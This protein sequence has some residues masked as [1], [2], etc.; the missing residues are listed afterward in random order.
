MSVS[1]Y[2]TYWTPGSLPPTTHVT[3]W[4]AGPATDFNPLDATPRPTA[5]KPLF[6]YDCPEG[7]PISNRLLAKT[8]AA[9]RPGRPL[10]HLL[11]QCS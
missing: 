5:M 9:L 4:L 2:M 1:L 8:T 10:L 7:G 11:A 3:S 6:S